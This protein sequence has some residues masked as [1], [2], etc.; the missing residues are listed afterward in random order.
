MISEEEKNKHICSLY[1][2]EERIVGQAV[3]KYCVLP[4][5][6]KKLRRSDLTRFVVQR[7]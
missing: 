6:I 4:Y 5:A 1:E 3:T 7:G 2:K